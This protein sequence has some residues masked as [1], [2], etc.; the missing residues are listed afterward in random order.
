M[1]TQVPTRVEIICFDLTDI[2]TLPPQVCIPSEVLTPS[3]PP[4]IGCGVGARIQR[5]Y[6]LA[7]ASTTTGTSFLSRKVPPGAIEEDRQLSHT[8][9]HTP[10]PPQWCAD[11]VFARVP[12]LAS[13]ERRQLAV[14]R[15]A[16]KYGA[17]SQKPGLAFRGPGRPRPCFAQ[18]GLP[19]GFAVLR[20]A[21]LALL[22]A[23]GRVRHRHGVVWW[24]WW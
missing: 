9:A 19:A 7:S 18:P 15:V 22:G 11:G 8:R 12:K 4:C 16:V 5:V 20:A 10:P 2:V 17:P 14:W 23:L 13:R 24:W 1:K 6:R 3:P 21:D